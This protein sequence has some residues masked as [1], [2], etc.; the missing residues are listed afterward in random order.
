VCE[1][2][3]RH[4]VEKGAKVETSIVQDLLD[5]MVTSKEIAAINDWDGDDGCFP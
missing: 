4:K 5:M 1:G 2:T 3:E